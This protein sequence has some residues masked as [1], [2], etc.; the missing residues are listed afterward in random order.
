LSFFSIRNEFSFLFA[1]VTNDE[2]ASEHFGTH[3]VS[4]HF[5][6]DEYVVP[7]VQVLFLK[8][9]SIPFTSLLYVKSPCDNRLQFRLTSG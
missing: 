6:P 2:S 5:W 7:Q 9:L 8:K 4:V 3:F 1:Y